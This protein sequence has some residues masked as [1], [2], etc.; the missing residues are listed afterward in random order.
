MNNSKTKKLIELVKTH[1]SGKIDKLLVVGCGNGLE[2]AVL[3]QVLGV[4]VIGIDIKDNFNPQAAVLA[5]LRLGDAMALDFPDN[6]F[7]FVYSYHALEHISDPRKALH[8]IDRVLTPGGSYCVGTPNRSRV[9]GYLGSKTTLQKK[10][11]WNFTDWKSRLTGKFRNEY[12]AHA[13]FSASELEGLLRERF[14]QPMNITND[15]YFA[16]YHDR[17]RWISLL[18]HSRLDKWIFPSV[19]F[20]G[21]K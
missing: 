2:A 17:A 1:F 15:Y 18:I 9:I 13:G 14:H 6:Y 10:L 8:E 4:K 12:G 16:I 5:D 3:A 7:D 20:F 21:I 11:K 19:Y